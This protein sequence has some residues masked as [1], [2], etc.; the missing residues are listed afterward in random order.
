[1]D[2]MVIYANRAL[3]EV[4]DMGLCMAI[5]SQARSNRS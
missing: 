1:M 2:F 4:T 5:F 3:I